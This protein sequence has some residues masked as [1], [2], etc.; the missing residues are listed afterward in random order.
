MRTIKFAERAGLLSA[1]AFQAQAVENWCEKP[2]MKMK[3]SRIS[4]RT[5]CRVGHKLDCSSISERL[6]NQ[7]NS[8]LRCAVRF[9]WHRRIIFGQR[10][11]TGRRPVD[12]HGTGEDEAC[13]ACFRSLSH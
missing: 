10:T 6:S 4:C 1:K 8:S 3:R 12:A 13:D 11:G 2:P 7:V 5:A 9:V